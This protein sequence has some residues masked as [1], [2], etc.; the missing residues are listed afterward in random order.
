VLY[1]A[2][3]SK[4]DVETA[5]KTIHQNCCS[6][7]GLFVPFRTP[8]YTPT[9]ISHLGTKSF[10]QNVADILNIFFSAGIS[11]WDVEF[12][13]GRTPVK[14]DYIS[15]RIMIAECWHNSQWR[16]DYLVRAMSDRLRTENQGTEPT[17][18]VQIAVRI[19]V[20]F[21]TYGLLLGSGQTEVNTVLDVAVTSGDFAMPMAAWYAR[22]MGLPIG[23]IVCGCNANGSIWDLLHKGEMATSDVA[24]RTCTPDVDIAVPKNLE[25]LIYGTLGN[26]AIMQYLDCCCTGSLYAPDQESFEKLREGMF[27]SVISDERVQSS[28]YNVARTSGY[29]F[30]PYSAL[31]YASLLDYRAKTSESRNAL[32]ITERSPSCDVELV[33]AFMRVDVAEVFRRISKK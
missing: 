16:F 29:V 3:R 21:A 18:W 4:N 23:N 1:A 33:A 17:N 31:A 28:I 15:H 7:G 30:G 5:Y 10:G 14:M 26:A 13:I 32:L 8:T 19:A 12:A 2:T 11:G 9:E 22:K 20:L 24:T 6:D 25:R 27:A